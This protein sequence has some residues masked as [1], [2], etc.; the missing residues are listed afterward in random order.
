M[1]HSTR[2][3]LSRRSTEELEGFLKYCLNKGDYRDVVLEILEILK[4][5][6]VFTYL[7]DNENGTDD[8]SHC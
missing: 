8:P 7:T 1:D 2:K 5:C 3:Y 6:D 4:E